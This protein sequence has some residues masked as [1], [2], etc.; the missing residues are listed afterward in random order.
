MKKEVVIASATRTPIGRFLGGISSIPAPELGAIA[1]REAVKRAGIKPED[2]E[3]VIMGNVCGAGVGQAPARQASIKAGIPGDVGATT[4]NKVC[5]SGLKAVVFA[6]QAIQA[7]DADLIVAGGMESMSNVPHYLK[8]GRSGQKLGDQNLIDGVVSDG[9]WCSFENQ[10]MGN[11]AE[12]TATN[13]KI[14]RDEQD[15][16]AFKSHQ[17]A[18]KA[19][20]DCKFQSET[21]SVEVPVKRGDNIVVEKDE[22]PR[23]DTSTEKLAT[24]RPAFVKE[25]TVTAG[26]APGLN[27]GA[28]A[29]VVMSGDKAKKLGNKPLAK[30]T[31]YATGGGEPKM[32]FYAPIVAV[33]K[34]LQKLEYKIDDFDLIEI[35]EAF[36]VQALADGKELGWNWDKV[37]V[38]GGAVALGH[39]IG[40]SGARILTTLIYALKDRN[41]KK[42]LATLCLGGGNAVALSVEMI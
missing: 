26:N 22:S 20:Q 30:I 4:I 21:I 40:A 23:A 31:G 6:A 12:F 2:V 13:S 17:K 33:K 35:N 18:V 8:T 7:D 16:Y 36:S 15:E 32:L 37:N 41:L 25:G 11:I 27:D 39:P 42:G 29:L 1:I 3:E 9:L 28:S 38:N 14:S 24:L 10:H 19:I 34:L 5:A